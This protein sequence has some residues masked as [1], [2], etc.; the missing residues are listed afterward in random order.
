MFPF[1]FFFSF[2]WCWNTK[3][4]SGTSSDSQTPIGSTSARRKMFCFFYSIDFCREAGHWTLF[5]P[6]TIMY[7]FTS[8]T[9]LELREV[10]TLGLEC[11]V[12]VPQELTR[13]RHGRDYSSIIPVPHFHM[14]KDVVPL[15]LA[16]VLEL[17][18][19]KAVSG[20]SWGWKS[21]VYILDWIINN[22]PGLSLP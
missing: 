11:T 15:Y 17:F 3:I 8:V 6:S 16:S 19:G 22:C 18:E 21:C 9:W 7:W 5:F 1:F 13:R 12:C 14:P 2:R 20:T 4:R 10:H